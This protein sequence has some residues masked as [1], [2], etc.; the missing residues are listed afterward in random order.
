MTRN[1]IQLKW[2]K[3]PTGDIT[4]EIEQI[5]HD[6]IQELKNDDMRITGTLLVAN[7]SLLFDEQTR[8]T[9]KLKRC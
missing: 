4:P 8:E 6:T 3:E 1:N 5:T 9:T 2:Q 7:V